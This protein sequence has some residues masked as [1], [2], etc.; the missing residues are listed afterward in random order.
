MHGDICIRIE[1]C[2]LVEEMLIAFLLPARHCPNYQ[3]QLDTTASGIYMFVM[4]HSMKIMIKQVLL[5][6]KE[7]NIISGVEIV[8]CELSEK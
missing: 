6:K 1:I 4:R 2:Y 3:H 8:D 7:R 5:L